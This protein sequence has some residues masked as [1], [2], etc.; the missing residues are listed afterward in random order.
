MSNAQTRV[1]MTGVEYFGS[2]VSSV[3]IVDLRLSRLAASVPASNE[4]WMSE[5][6]RL[7]IARSRRR[8]GNPE[9]E[10]YAASPRSRFRCARPRPLTSREY[11]QN[12][13]LASYW[14][15]RTNEVGTAGPMRVGVGL[16]SWQKRCQNSHARRPAGTNATMIFSN[17]SSLIFVMRDFPANCTIATERQ[18][19]TEFRVWS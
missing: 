8:P 18:I 7:S 14:E 11:F 12:D 13:A 19:N 2:L 15:L 17:P 4:D 9:P 3:A 16:S 1:A 10:R 5:S 6:L